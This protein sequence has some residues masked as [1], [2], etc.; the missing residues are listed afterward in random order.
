MLMFKIT[1]NINF[2]LISYNHAIEIVIFT[3]SFT[4]IKIPKFLITIK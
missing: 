2:I 3:I 4:N 1:K